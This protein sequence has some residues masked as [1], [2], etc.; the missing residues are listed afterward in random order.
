ML[1]ALLVLGLFVV[2]LA[3]SGTGAQGRTL[4]D[5]IEGVWNYGGGQV[6]VTQ[7]GA[8]GHF[9]GTVTTPTTLAVCQHPAGQQM[10]DI[11]AAGGNHYTGTHIGFHSGGCSE[12]PGWQATWDVSIS[13]SVYTLHFCTTDPSTGAVPCNDLTRAAPPPEPSVAHV[14][15]WG[16]NVSVRGSRTTRTITA[17]GS[18]TL[19]TQ[20]ATSS[21]S[22]V[23]GLIRLKDVVRSTKQSAQVSFRPSAVIGPFQGGTLELHV[24]IVGSS[25]RNCRKGA[26]GFATLVDGGGS[27]P[28]SFSLSACGTHLDYIDRRPSKGTHVLVLIGEQH[29]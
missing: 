14:Y 2:S 12:F 13:G 16:A 18:L 11:T 7:A 27:A 1:R 6:T 24:T 23:S 26:G 5:P 22:G 17:N 20:G 25:F 21:V 15:L 19:Q 8:A 4:S 10:W 29:S 28:D 3:G 9:V